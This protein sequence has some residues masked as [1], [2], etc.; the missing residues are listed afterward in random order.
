MRW[1]RQDSAHLAE[2]YE[3]LREEAIES[4]YRGHRGHGLALFLARGMTAWLNALSA[5]APRSVTCSEGQCP[6]R[7]PPSAHSDITSLLAN[8]VLACS[9]QVAP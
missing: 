1:Y 5:L 2:Q 4:C 3:A 7:V 9:S 8:M 6:G